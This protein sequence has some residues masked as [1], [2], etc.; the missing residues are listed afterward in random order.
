M[1]AILSPRVPS[2]VEPQLP[3]AVT[4]S[5]SITLLFYTTKFPNKI[6]CVSWSHLQNKILVWE[7]AFWRTYI[8]MAS[9]TLLS[10]FPSFGLFND[11]VRP[12]EGGASHLSAAEVTAA[13]VPVPTSMGWAPSLRQ[14]F[15][16]IKADMQSGSVPT[17]GS[18]TARM[19]SKPVS[20]RVLYSFS[21]P[22]AGEQ[23]SHHLAPHHLPPQLGAHSSPSLLFTQLWCV[24]SRQAHFSVKSKIAIILDF[25]GYTIS[26]T[27]I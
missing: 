3:I 11:T 13:I 8:E 21:S 7:S 15:T 24:R 16:P 25:V 1:S 5:I 18:A 22:K 20:L 23:G 4:S 10:S 26:V 2:R 9:I 12:W 17:W 6:T 14:P 19:C 27:T